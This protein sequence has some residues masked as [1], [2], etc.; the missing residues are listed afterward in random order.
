MKIFIL[1]LLPALLWAAE[2]PKV[3]H[4]KPS[5]IVKLAKGQ[6]PLQTPYASFVA[7]GDPRL[8]VTQSQLHHL[9]KKNGNR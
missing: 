3:V 4:K 8:S 5:V 1:L 9:M 2:K 6:T 7:P